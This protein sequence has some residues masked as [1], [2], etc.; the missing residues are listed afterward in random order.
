MSNKHL[1][2]NKFTQGGSTSGNKMLQLLIPPPSYHS[3]NFKSEY[4][5]TCPH[6]GKCDTAFL[7]YT[8][9]FSYNIICLYGD[10]YSIT[11]KYL[12]LT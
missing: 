2:R 9:F 3:K 7:L 5:K 1:I 4:N 6:L 10:T 12:L 8:Q 11:K